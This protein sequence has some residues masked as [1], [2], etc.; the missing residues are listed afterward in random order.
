[1]IPAPGYSGTPTPQELG[2]EH[3]QPALFIALR[4]K[5]PAWRNAIEALRPSWSRRA[6]TVATGTTQ[7]TIGAGAGCGAVVAVSAVWSGLK[8]VIR[9][10]LR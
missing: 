8:L 1:M 2:L 6:G 3:G 5:V 4:G 10:E 7:K 9:K